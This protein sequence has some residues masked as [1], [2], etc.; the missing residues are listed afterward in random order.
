MSR[1]EAGWVVA[2][3]RCLLLC[4]NLFTLGNQRDY[5]QQ[6]HLGTWDPFGDVTVAD[7]GD[8]AVTIRVATTSV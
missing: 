4:L 1:V 3:M 6:P 8:L 7:R 2:S 5:M